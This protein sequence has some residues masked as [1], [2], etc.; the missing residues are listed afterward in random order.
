MAATAANTEYVARGTWNLVYTEITLDATYA[1][2]GESI[3]ADLFGM[4]VIKAIWPASADGYICD[5]VRSSDT[6]WL[7]RMY[8]AGTPDTNSALATPL[9]SSVGRDLSAV[10]IPCLVLGR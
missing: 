7:M 8:V 9:Q 2:G 5:P 3:S 1:S 10:V 6:T 4:K